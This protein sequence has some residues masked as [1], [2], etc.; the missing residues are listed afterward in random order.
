MNI[1]R[2]IL[3]GAATLVVG[4]AALADQDQTGMVT[5]IDRLNHTIAIQPI[6]SGTVG[7]NTGGAAAATAEQFKADDGVS[8]EEVHAGDRVNFSVRDGG[9]AK[10]VT[11]LQRQK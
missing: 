9:G 6:Q 5:Q 3:A 1:A 2:I 10:T 11:K 7:A 4:T 8:L